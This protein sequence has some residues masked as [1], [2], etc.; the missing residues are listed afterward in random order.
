MMDLIGMPFPTTIPVLPGWLIKLA[1][2]MFKPSKSRE[3]PQDVAERQRWRREF[4]DYVQKQAT[5]TEQQV[6]AQL[7]EDEE[8]FEM[9]FNALFCNT[10]ED[11][12]YYRKLIKSLSAEEIRSDLYPLFER[13]V[14]LLVQDC[15]DDSVWNLR[16]EKEDF[17]TAFFTD[18]FLG[19]YIN[20]I[21]DHEEID[22]NMLQIGLEFLFDKFLS[23]VRITKEESGEQ[24]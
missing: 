2:A 3:T 24:K 19:F 11:Y 22:Y 7:P 21:R 5:A 23:T 1:K 14:R 8:P 9:W 13:R 16:K 12:K 15:L 4:T 17:S 10:C 18:A 6:A 20:Y